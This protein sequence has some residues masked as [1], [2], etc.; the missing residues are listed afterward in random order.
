MTTRI[1]HVCWTRSLIHLLNICDETHIKNYYEDNTMQRYD[2]L[3]RL[4]YKNKK[5]KEVKGG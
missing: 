4:S 5:P 1:I 3:F 2:E